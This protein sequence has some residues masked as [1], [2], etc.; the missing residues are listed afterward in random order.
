MARDKPYV[1]GQL[2]LFAPVSDWVPPRE[3]PD[4]RGRPIVALDT[5]TKDDGLAAGRGPGWALGPAGYLCGVSWAAEGSS[6]YA[7][8][9]HPD[10]ECLP[11]DNV[12]RW[13]D[14]LHRSGTRVV[15]HNGPYDIGWLGALGV[16]DPVNMEDT[17]AA[18]VMCDE[19]HNAYSLDACCARAGVPGKDTALLVEAVRAYGGNPKRPQADL[20]RLPAR[21]AGP[22]AERDTVSTLGLWHQLAPVL[23][24][25]ELEAAYRTEIDLIPMVVAMRRRGIR[26][27]VDRAFRT[28]AEFR[29]RRDVALAE[30][31]AKLTMRR[32]VTVD[33]LRSPKFME[34]L[35]R[36]N[37][38][39]FPRTPKSGQG[40]FS[41]DWMEKHEHWLPR[42][43]TQV[44]KYEEAA[45]KFVDN[46][47]LS[48]AHRGRLH[49][50]V[51]QFKSD[52]GGTR[53]HRFSYSEPPLQQMPSPDKDPTDEF[54]KIILDRAVGTPL[55][56]CF[57]PEEGELWGAPDYSQQEP[58][59]TVH[60]AAACRA[61][62]A[63]A[64]VDRY[65]KNPKT[66][67]HSM[68]A[69]MTGKP[70]PQAKILNLA[71][72]Y[73]KGLRSLAEE[74]GVTLEEARVILEDYHG[75]LPF[76]KSL[77]DI[78][79]TRASSRGYIRLIDG[80]RMRY[81]QW[82]GGWIDY[83]VRLAA[84]RAGKRMNP[85]SMDEAK[86]RQQD[87]DHPWSRTRL[88]RADTR[89][90]LNNLIQG[91]AARQ[92]KIAMLRMWREGVLPLIQM[93]DEVGISV[94]SEAVLRRVESIMIDAVPLKVPVIV[95]AE[96]GPNWGEAKYSWDAYVAKFGEPRLAA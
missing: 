24:A 31:G 28:G 37:G 33:D 77:E 85:C 9:R 51:H 95:D 43:T 96:V 40:S 89:K 18:A 48:F 35:F 3:L 42:M 52:E 75:R 76:I 79:K 25:Q 38:I 64:A 88:R 71:M 14:D 50:E 94:G 78:C 84:E 56:Q 19:T 82:E 15:F 27:D 10:T 49:A 66:D 70:R 80:A 4:L 22:Y 93:H 62:G 47:L 7:P 16:S 39:D 57:L 60:F 23:R 17:L 13:V 58:R 46:Y 69:E 90:A 20:W 54:K 63:D 81:T 8:V 55:R 92:T 44:I 6:G 30:I 87:P 41:K 11:L 45:N 67:Y 21:Y 61:V 74:L 53:S 65:L 1:P 83:E 12:L 32:A 68:V 73:G 26:L 29:R 59:I 2:G 5:E 34:A 36:E 72:T 91:S 86:L